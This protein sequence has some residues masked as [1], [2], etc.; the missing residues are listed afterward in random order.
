MTA[1]GCVPLA[2][3]CPWARCVDAMMSPSL[4]P[5]HH[6]DGNGL[7]ADR[8]VQE[9]RQ[10]AGAEALLDL[11]LETA[12][13]QHLAEELAQPLVGQSCSRSRLPLDLGHGAVHLSC[14]PMRLVAQWRRIEA[15]LPTGW[16][17]ARLRSPSPLR[18]SS[19]GRPRCSV[20]RTPVDPA[21]PC[22]SRRTGGGTGVGPD[23]VGRLLERLDG[24]RIAGT[25]TLRAASERAAAEPEA[26]TTLAAAWETALATLPPDW[27]DLLGEVE[28]VSTDYL[29]RAALLLSPL[30]PT[31][32]PAKVAFR[33]RWPAGSA[34]AR[35]PQMVRRCLERVDEDGIRGRVASCARS[36]TRRTSPRRARSGTSAG[37][38]V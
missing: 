12:D 19:P 37:K 20:L 30:N 15:E 2:S 13:Q 21:T 1:F 33:F 29:Q 5:G 17:E 18:R 35:R 31:R 9:A 22:S 11:L 26:V 28:L 23:A 27:S 34:T 8:D 6:A 36:P 24:E 7:L 10:L 14:D 4:E 38:P 32:D 3:V 16:S 25:L